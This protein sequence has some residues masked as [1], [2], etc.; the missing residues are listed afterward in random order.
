MKKNFF[1][2]VA[3]LIVTLFT[4]EIVLDSTLG[5]K[6]K[7]NLANNRYMLFSEGDV[8]QN[9]DK[10]FKYHANKKIVSRTF[11]D[12]KNS[13]IEEYDYTIQTNNYGLVQKNDIKKNK[14]SILFLGDSFT[15]GQG[16]YSWV[17][18]FNGS[19]KDY[20]VINGGILGTGF[21]Q[22]ELLEKHISND[23]DVKKVIVLY[24]GDDLRRDLFNHSEQ[25]INCLKS[26]LNCSG[27]ENFYSFNPISLNDHLNFLK[28]QRINR[29]SDNKKTFKIYKRQVKKYISQLSI[30]FYPYQFLKNNFY[31]SKNVKIISNLESI[32]NLIKK[33]K[34]NIIFVGLKQKNEITNGDS[35]NSIR[36]KKHIQ[37]TSKLFECDFNNDLNNFYKHD[38]HPNQAG[39]KYLFECVQN[40]LNENYQ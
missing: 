1:L 25:V 30:F 38:G 26:Y 29:N 4:I 35:Y 17:D 22:F 14:Q 36:V 6:N 20:Q 23:Y 10:I 40:I 32:D 34:S 13:F 21:K 16:Y 33:Y 18:K 19:Y 5:D 12:V 15:E 28:S 8:F 37:K 27:Y 3:T 11:Y 31:E 2:L 24:L 9:V 39:Y 7:K